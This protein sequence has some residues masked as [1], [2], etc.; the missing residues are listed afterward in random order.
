MSEEALVAL[1][2]LREEVDNLAK[3]IPGTVSRVSLRVGEIEI[4]IEWAAPAGLAAAPG[5][6]PVSLPAAQPVAAPQV[7]SDV[8]DSIR[9][10]AAP[11]V[12][13]FYIASE[14]GSA[15]FVQPGDKVDSGQ[16]IGIVEAMKLMN[17]IPTEWVGEVLEVLV[18][19]GE[20]VEFDQPLVR[21]R[22]ERE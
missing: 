22:L 13:T 14:P 7:D 1:R 11:L 17:Q 15:P 4:E 16:P 9:T 21:L 18:K 19:D 10:V 5:P 8:D 12:G 6:A 2:L 3:G 20:P